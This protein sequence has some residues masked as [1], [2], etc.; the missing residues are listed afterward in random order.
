MYLSQSF[1]VY[2]LK[3]QSLSEEEINCKWIRNKESTMKGQLNELK[4][5]TEYQ[6]TK[7]VKG[8]IIDNIMYRLRLHYTLPYRVN[9]IK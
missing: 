1:P 6:A 2:G 9:I 3:L 4:N 7:K 5:K 8:N